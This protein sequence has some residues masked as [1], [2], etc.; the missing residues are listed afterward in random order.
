MRFI[1]TV[2]SCTT[3]DVSIM[4]SALYA[5]SATLHKCFTQ[6][7]SKLIRRYRGVVPKRRGKPP[8]RTVTIGVRVTPEQARALERAAA[9][10]KVDLSTFARLALWAEAKKH[11][12]DL[13]GLPWA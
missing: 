6:L 9:R 4:P 1:V 13:P 12:I 11:G 5:R 8:K 7:A 2:S 10:A 3:R